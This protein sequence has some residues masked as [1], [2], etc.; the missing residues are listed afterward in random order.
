MRIMMMPPAVCIQA[1]LLSGV[2][3]FGEGR[4]HYEH[5]HQPAQDAELGTKNQLGFIRTESRVFFAPHSG[6]LYVG[7]CFGDVI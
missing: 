3:K 2:G 7:P 4:A 6:S 1:P 5:S